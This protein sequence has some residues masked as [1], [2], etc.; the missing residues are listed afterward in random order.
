M[1]KNKDKHRLVQKFTYNFNLITF[2]NHLFRKDQSFP[3]LYILS[4]IV[5]AKLTKHQYLLRRDFINSKRA[6]DI[7]PSYQSLLTAKKGCYRNDTLNTF[8]LQ[9]LKRN[10]YR[11]VY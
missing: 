1:Y 10:H 4:I 5:E 2:P 9:N 7:S 6:C 11:K 3:Y 8:V